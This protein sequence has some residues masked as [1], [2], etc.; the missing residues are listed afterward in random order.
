MCAPRRQ[1]CASSPDQLRSA[2][3]DTTLQAQLE[4]V[5]GQLAHAQ[6][7][8]AG[9]RNE[10]RG[11]KAEVEGLAAKFGEL[12]EGARELAG[13]FG[14]GFGIEQ[15]AE[16]ISH[17]AEMG[18]RFENSAAA[19][20]AKAGDYAK[21]AGAFQLVGGNA[22]TATRTIQLVERNITEALANPNSS[23]P[24]PKSG[25]SSRSTAAAITM[26]RRRSTPT[27]RHLGT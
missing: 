5:S 19:I 3:S 16:G 27:G 14:V 22:E 26:T 15:I 13:I 21:L 4:R 20:G 6:A 18:E 11:H 17:L 7:A 1:R 12:T 10:L 8:A 9:F 2:A 25:S 24:R 23:R